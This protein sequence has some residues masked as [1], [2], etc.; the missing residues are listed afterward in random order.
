[1]YP[2]RFLRIVSLVFTCSITNAWNAAAA[3]GPCRQSGP[4]PSGYLSYAVKRTP[5]PVFTL[6]GRKPYRDLDDEVCLYY[7]EITVYF[8]HEKE[9]CSE[10]LGPF[11]RSY[12]PFRLDFSKPDEQLW[13]WPG[14]LTLQNTPPPPVTTR[15]AP[16]TQADVAINYACNKIKKEIEVFDEN[17]PVKPTNFQLR[18]RAGEYVWLDVKNTGLVDWARPE[19]CD[20]CRWCV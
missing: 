6:Q 15:P 3:D 18:M 13:I 9:K 16:P 14:A 1:M 2:V 10:D 19:R 20:G 8:K 4:V 12:C 11:D 7:S 17:I 5:M